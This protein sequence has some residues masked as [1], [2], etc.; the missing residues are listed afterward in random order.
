MAALS[1]GLFVPLA[2]GMPWILVIMEST[3]LLTGREIYREMTRF[4]GKLFGIHFA[5]SVVARL[6]LAFYFG[7]QWSYQVQY[8]GDVFGALLAVASLMAIFLEYTCAGL[9]FFG[10]ERLS[11]RQ[12]L[13]VTFLL[14]LGSNLSALLTLAANSWM[15][16]PVG[17]EF[18]FETL[19]MEMTS[20]TALFLNPLAQLTFIHVTAASY[21]TGSLFVLGISAWYLLKERHVAFAER[22]FSVAAGFGLAAMLAILVLG[23]G[24]GY[25]SGDIQRTKLT[26]IGAIW[27]TQPPPVD[28][29]LVGLPNDDTMETR[30]A[31]HI[32]W[33]LGLMATRSAH[34]EV[35]GIKDLVEE[36]EW[37]IRNGMVAY[38]YLQRLYNGQTT[39]ENLAMFEEYKKDLGYGLLLE[40]LAPAIVD[41]TE[42]QI[43]QVAR[44]SIPPVA[45]VF[46][47]FRI[48]LVAGLLMLV[49][50]CL[51]FYH[52]ARQEILEK[53]W[54]LRL[55]VWS[56][57]L[58]WIAG[59]SGW[60]VAE[61]GR[62][63]WAI[64]EV[65]P[66]FL[67]MSNSPAG[68]LSFSL[69]GLTVFYAML[70]AVGLGLMLHCVRQGPM[71]LPAPATHPRTRF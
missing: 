32:P 17:A 39:Q 2:L 28:F 64:G 4:W 36:H 3:Y 16:N 65:L 69:M 25:E 21:I 6:A 22:S 15:Q 62:Q 24:S 60:F 45:P 40:R 70:G 59:E 71:S 57:P 20:F 18:N 44:D 66:D 33:L 58:P 29:T 37:R 61:F 68:E 34:T 30:W 1:R 55:V 8:A 54:L 43:A 38:R 23:D 26:L 19:R 53:R 47:A 27:E 13:A 31:V 7:T 51:S 14:A 48:M 52:N 35:T 49:V 41:A 63:P 56:M 67:A 11:R 9:F 5:L 42:A 50:L 10:W 12:H 46:W